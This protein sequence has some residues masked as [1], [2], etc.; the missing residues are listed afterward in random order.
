MCEVSVQIEMLP[1]AAGGLLPW[2]LS[3]HLYHFVAEPCHP[4]WIT[5]LFLENIFQPSRDQRLNHGPPRHHVNSAAH[6]ESVIV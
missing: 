3:E 6:R 2:T 5:P 1:E 4:L